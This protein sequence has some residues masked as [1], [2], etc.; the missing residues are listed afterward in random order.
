MWYEIIGSVGLIIWGIL[1]LRAFFLNKKALIFIS[2][3]DEFLPKKVLGKYYDR[4][5]NLVM[6]IIELLAGLFILYKLLI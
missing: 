4:T 2:Y 1:S 5:M 3:N 6:G